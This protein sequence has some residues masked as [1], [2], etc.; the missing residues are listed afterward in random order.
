MLPPAGAPVNGTASEARPGGLGPVR[1][2]EA[3]ST[4]PHAGTL[5][6]GSAPAEGSYPGTYRPIFSV[7]YLFGFP[8]SG[9]AFGAPGDLPVAGDWDGNGT[10]TIGVYRPST[11]VYYLRNTNSFDAPDL[12]IPYGSPGDFPVV[13]DWDG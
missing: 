2:S 5:H 6:V 4:R 9:F 7:F 11:N 3:N 12:V 10:T 1:A 8:E 13:G